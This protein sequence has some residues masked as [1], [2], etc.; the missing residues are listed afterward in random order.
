MSDSFSIKRIKEVASTASNNLEDHTIDQFNQLVRDGGTTTTLESFNTMM[1]EE[2][3]QEMAHLSEGEQETCITLMWH[4]HRITTFDKPPY[5]VEFT[6]PS[7]LQSINEIIRGVYRA[8]Q[9]DDKELTRLMENVVSLNF[10][11]SFGLCIS[12]QKHIIN[13]ISDPLPTSKPTTT[14]STISRSAITRPTVTTPQ[15]TFSR[16]AITKPYQFNQRFTATNSIISKSATTKSY[17]FN[18]TATQQAFTATSSTN[19]KSAVTKSTTTVKQLA[20]S[21]APKEVQDL[22]NNTVFTASILTTLKL[23]DIKSMS[24]PWFQFGSNC[25]Y[26]N[27]FELTAMFGKNTLPF[28]EKI[29][30]S[31]VRHQLIYKIPPDNPQGAS[32]KPDLTFRRV[33]EVSTGRMEVVAIGEFKVSDIASFPNP[34]S[35]P[36]LSTLRQIILGAVA[37][38]CSLIY[39]ITPH[40]LYRLDITSKQDQGRGWKQ[41]SFTCNRF[42]SRVNINVSFNAAWYMLHRMPEQIPGAAQFKFQCNEL[43]ETVSLQSLSMV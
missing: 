15:S 30:N 16:A 9:S 40:Q 17:P 19:S 20:V 11:F 38:Q 4:A 7:I 43:N 6:N 41:Y 31:Q 23:R 21:I 34:L 26:S 22:Y 5:N 32:F 10:L 28:V 8:C 25:Q 13:P 18:Q 35:N 14:S 37:A 42:D 36:H 3:S 27:E 39:L 12:F 2:F 1:H 29:A 33:L 24:L